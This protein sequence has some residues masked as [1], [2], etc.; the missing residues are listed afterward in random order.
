MTR[1]H[2]AI[3]ALA[4][5]ALPATVHAGYGKSDVDAYHV[6]VHQVSASSSILFRFETTDL[7][8]GADTEIHVWNSTTG[9][10]VT[11]NDDCTPYTVASC[12]QFRAAANHW[13]HIIVISYP[14]STPTGTCDLI[15]K[16][17]GVQT[18]YL[19]DIPV[20]GT[21][22]Y[23]NIGSGDAVQTALLNQ[24]TDDTVLYGFDST[25][26]VAVI[27]DDGGV[28]FA[29]RF[30][31]TT[32]I[33]WVA[34]GTYSTG[35]GMARVLVNDLPQ[36]HD[37]DGVGP[38]LEASMCSCDYYGQYSCWSACAVDNYK[39]SD[40]D[41]LS[42]DIETFGK[43]LGTAPQHLPKW[44]AD[45]ARMDLFIEADYWES[46]SQKVWESAALDVARAYE[47]EAAGSGAH[48]RNRDGSNGIRVHLDIG[49][50]STGTTY[51]AWGGGG[52]GVPSGVTDPYNDPTYFDPARNGVFH[53]VSVTGPASGQSPVY[54]PT[55]TAAYN[56]GEMIAHELGHNVGL[57]HYG[58]KSALDVNAKP[59]YRSIMNYAFGLSNT[60]P[61]FS[62]GTFSQVGLNPTGLCE[63]SGLQTADRTKVQHL[64][65]APYS[66]FVEA[67]CGGDGNPYC[68]VD[69]NRDGTISLCSTVVRAAPNQ[70][71]G[72]GYSPELG[73]YLWQ[74]GPDGSNNINP[75]FPADPDEAS[76]P[77]L[78][79]AFGRMHLVFREV[80]GWIK[81]LYTSHDFK[82]G[83]GTPDSAGCAPWT[84][85][86]VAMAAN[87]AGPA[88]VAFSSGATPYLMVVYKIGGALEYKVF[89]SAYT[90]VASGAI[91]QTA[92]AL[93]EPVLGVQE[94]QVVLLY[95]T[96]TMGQE[97]PIYRKTYTLGG[98][99]TSAV[100]QSRDGQAML[101]YSAAALA[102]T[103][104]GGLRAVF[105]RYLYP[106]TQQLIWAEYQGSNAWS[107]VSGTGMETHM[108]TSTQARRVGLTWRPLGG[109][110]A[111]GRWY[112]VYNPMNVD[113]A[114]GIG[115]P[116]LDMTRGDGA[117]GPT[118]WENLSRYDNVWYKVKTG[119]ELLGGS[120]EEGLRLT[121]I[122]RRGPGDLHLH[123][124]PF[125]DGIVDA[126]M[127]DVND[128]S[129]MTVGLCHSLQTCQ[130]PNSFCPG[131]C[132]F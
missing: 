124:R 87:E 110:L 71:R 123:F 70:L 107:T 106:D 130:D 27:N 3:S 42:D 79:R 97:A 65:A 77:G 7:K 80:S 18:A 30:V 111:G 2:M 31:A 88:A 76:T 86:T 108:I 47:T 126:Q 120:A 10:R 16:R 94:G 85:L 29:S 20:G 11:W 56:S 129:V 68:G 122:L 54:A 114:N 38:A 43:W 41:G 118:V 39:D 115:T 96:G 59:H 9:T 21:W 25:G 93:F 46:D 17:N 74:W 81:L 98:G 33:S 84:L 67:S 92:G 36:D 51:G 37:G 116:Y 91:F 113:L 48:L 8:G 132:V 131:T 73:R 89:N 95:R 12:L 63:A 121:T 82:Q 112:L 125:A 4:M 83:C 127:Y 90:A 45:P 28:P 32:A 61:H 102:S 104:T 128:W 49:R 34:T 14:D 105:T 6:R 66:L 22:T 103:P 55:F 23:A 101:A 72:T 60:N 19:N 50:S 69:W 109:G 62:L 24:G 99:W 44:G 40:Y 100:A 75:L 13:Y 78:A 117:S 26:G 1:L 5:L 64:E 53:Y 57:N 119:V 58:L 35:H 52:Q 15:E